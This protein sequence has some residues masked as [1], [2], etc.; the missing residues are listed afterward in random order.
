MPVTAAIDIR[1]PMGAARYVRR[2]KY[3]WPGG[4]ALAAIT[5]DGELLCPACLAENWPQVSY[6]TRH[7]LT[8]GWRVIGLTGEHE[9]DGEPA[10]CAHCNRELWGSEL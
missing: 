1:K 2:E 7:N 3:A 9:A 5:S 8:D 10:R 4:Y 6:A